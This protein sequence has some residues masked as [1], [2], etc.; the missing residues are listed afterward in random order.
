MKILVTGASGFVGR[1]VT[2]ALAACY[3]EA[4]ITALGS[5][6]G[7][8]RLDLT[9][10][11]AVADLVAGLRP[12]GVVHLAAVSAVGVARADPDAAWRLN[13]HAT[14]DLARA[15]LTHVPACRMVFASSSETYGASFRR[16][17][18]LDETAP[19]APQ[20]VYAATKAAADLALGAMAAEGL[21]VVRLRP[22]NHT[23]PGQG[24]GFVVPAFARQVARIAEGLQAPVMTVGALDPLRDFLDVRDVARAYAACLRP[25][26]AVTPGMVLNLASGRP[27]RIGD[28]LTDL[29]ALAGVAARIET[30]Q[31][32]L[33]PSDIRFAVGD[34][35]AAE[36]VL[37]WRPEITWAQTL[38]DVLDDWKRRGV[39]ELAASP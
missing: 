20:N 11:A 14:I 12:D 5:A 25:E 30:G 15:L 35:A 13:L 36:A 18:A 31:A 38:R 29:L 24:E 33:R 6:P 9:D 32:L 1:H 39:K 37:G 17:V 2:A 22:F 34:A 7:M 10:R 21:A 8:V 26:L 19:L 23:G 16:G 4:E 28:I 3:P 27:M